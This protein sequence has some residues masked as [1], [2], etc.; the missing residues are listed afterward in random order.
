MPALTVLAPGTLMTTQDAGRSGYA[1][2]GVGPSGPAD[3]RS[4][5]L[6]NR[7]VGNPGDA[8]QLEATFGGF[9]LR[10]N[11]TLT[12]A[13]TGAL[14]ELTVLRGQRR[15]GAATHSV[16]TLRPGDELRA[17]TPSAGLRN[18]I[19]VRGGLRSEPVLGSSS[20]DTLSGL[21][22]RAVTAGQDF[23]LAGSF[24]GWP[25][26]D[27]AHWPAQLGRGTADLLLSV[28][29]GP[30]DDWFLAE[31]IRLL[32][33][34]RWTVT[35]Q[36]NRVAI[37]L[38]GKEPLTRTIAMELPSEGVLAGAIQVP[39]DGKPIAFLADHPVT[40][41]YPVIGVLDSGSLADAAQLRPGEHL[42]FEQ[43]VVT[44]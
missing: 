20:T 13:V 12:I 14:V 19:A 16:L 5:A 29:L 17:G 2:Y 36:S 1:R 26:V 8:T 3:R 24:A 37:R 42:R 27:L 22:P 35:T 23:E 28:I 21:G 25:V 4:A 9:R 11:V 30:R 6:A 32:F 18:Y 40:G 38:D 15:V 31:S 41:G 43:K 39:A 34:Q 10:A 33:S 44:W 7:L